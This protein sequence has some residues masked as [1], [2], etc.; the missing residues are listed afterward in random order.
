MYN[1]VKFVINKISSQSFKNKKSFVDITKYNKKYYGKSNIV[2][3]K[4]CSYS[5]PKPPN[6]NLL[7]ITS[8]LCG[9]LLFYKNK[10]K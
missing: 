5:N 3:R 10:I 8:V 2:I 1:R 7:I 6:N 4:F 9:G